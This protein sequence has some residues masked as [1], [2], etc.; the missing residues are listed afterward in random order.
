MEQFEKLGLSKDLLSVLQEAGFKT[1]TE[2]QE[3]TIPLALAGK[4]IIGGSATGSG[5]TL[6]FLIPIL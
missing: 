1:P 5:K 2:I 3:K 6:A 4:D